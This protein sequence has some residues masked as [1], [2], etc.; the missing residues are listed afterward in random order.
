MRA[1]LPEMREA[2]QTILRL[3]V[4]QF[5]F[6]ADKALE[7]VSPERNGTLVRV[8]KRGRYGR[9][10]RSRRWKANC[11]AAGFFDAAAARGES[12]GPENLS[13]LEHSIIIG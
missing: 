3:T 10:I 11:H 12:P 13:F 6:F 5:L 8:M 7:P 4:E 2:V 9:A 1:I